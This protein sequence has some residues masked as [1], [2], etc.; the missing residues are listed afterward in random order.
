M[1]RGACDPG[2]NPAETSDSGLCG[3][4]RVLDG[5]YQP[6]H[7]F[8]RGTQN[9][10]SSFYTF[11]HTKYS[12]SLLYLHIHSHIYAYTLSYLYI[13]IIIST[14]THSRIYASSFS[15][16][17]IRTLILLLIL[18]F[19]HAHSHNYAYT[20]TNPLYTLTQYYVTFD[21][22]LNHSVKTTGVSTI[23]LTVNNVKL[24]LVDVG[25]D[26]EQRLG[27]DNILQHASAV[28]WVS[29]L[30]EFDQTSEDHSMIKMKETLVVLQNLWKTS[31]LA[32]VPFFFVFTKRDVF[33]QKVRRFK[34]QTNY[35]QLLQLQKN[36]LS[37][38]FGEAQVPQE[39]QLKSTKLST[40]DLQ[41]Q[42]IQ[43]VQQMFTEALLE[44]KVAHD[45][46]DIQNHSAVVNALETSEVR[47]A[48]SKIFHTLVKD[49]QQQI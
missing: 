23:E 14:H 11:S 26:K 22:V 41:Q 20:F 7:G 12:G 42:S 36:D 8:S 32:N 13:F 5:Q 19:T 15:H 10:F 44:T 46:V 21:D 18:T 48:V 6:H 24:R 1:D 28:V 40:S 2:G 31:T 3:V 45:K 38:A 16:L 39:L 27:W 47:E 35:D 29:S 30:S 33:A 43:Y 9:F 25:G 4:L 37:L 49:K 34:F 17:C